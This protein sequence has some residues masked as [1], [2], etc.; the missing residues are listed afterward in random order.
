MLAAT[1]LSACAAMAAVQAVAAPP[2]TPIAG[3]AYA[4]AQ[5]Q[6]VAGSSSSGGSLEAAASK[7]GE[8][9]RKVAMSLIAT[10]LAFASV[11][12]VFR[13]RFKDAA[14]VFAVGFTAVLLASP[15]GV[16]VLRDTV[17]LLFGA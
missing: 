3:S 6:P 8:L 9:G 10:G 14:G 7:A 13:R 15:A 5:A 11:V 2:R 16:N 17:K 1:L 12:L 4:P